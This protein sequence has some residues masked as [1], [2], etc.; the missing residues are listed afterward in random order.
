MVQSFKKWLAYACAHYPTPLPVGVAEFKAW[1]DSIF[2]IFGLP[3][4]P[5]YRQALASMVMHLGPTVSRQ[6]KAFFAKSV[7]KAMANQVAYEMIQSLKKQEQEYISSTIYKDPSKAPDGA[8]DPSPVQAAA[9]E[10][11]PQA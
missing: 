11:V 5:S 8:D 9:E 7:K 2:Q 1:S 4:M 6:P 10:V 3:D